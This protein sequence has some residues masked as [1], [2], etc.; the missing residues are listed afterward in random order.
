MD[1]DALAGLYSRGVK[2]CM[3]RNRSAA[4]HYRAVAAI[5]GT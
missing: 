2:S 3:A 4:E 5:I 1:F